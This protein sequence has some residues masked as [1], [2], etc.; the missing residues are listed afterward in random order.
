MAGKLRERARQLKE[1][2]PGYGP[3]LD[4]Y[5][6]V[7]EAQKASTPRVQ[8]AR[9][10]AS[11]G[12]EAGQGFPR[13][14]DAG[15]PVDIASSVGLFG[16]LCRLGKA[17][18]PHFATQAERIERAVTSGV[19]NLDA[20]LAGG[21]RDATAEQAAIERGLDARILSFLVRNSTRPSIE[22]ARER[23]LEGFAPEAWR[24]PSCPV[25][26]AP[27]AVSILKGDPVLRH[28]LCSYCGC[29][30]QVDRLS[31]SVCGNN[32][33]DSLQ[34]FH[35][36]GEMA[37]RIDL[38]DKCRHYIKTI[39]VRALEAPDPCMEDLATLHLDLV[40]REKGYSRIVPNPWS[41]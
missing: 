15:F 30:W 7:R 18:N 21:G 41:A 2:W 10:R 19:L 34:Y 31:C 28:S 20:L 40:A 32:D 35:G 1:K 38:C 8:V 16:T 12:R 27:P 39:G 33:K 4:F 25:C 9:G 36:E 17:A 24:K 5:V 29:E 37:C 23:L 6:V 14:G 13:I 11:G 22:A 3:L 26:G